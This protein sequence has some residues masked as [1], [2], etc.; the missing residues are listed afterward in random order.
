MAPDARCVIPLAA[1][2]C[3]WRTDSGELVQ[4]FPTKF[5]SFEPWPVQWTNEEDFA[6]RLTAEGA[7]IVLPGDLSTVIPSSRLAKDSA[8][9]F[10]VGPTGLPHGVCTF[11][12]R[13][14]S[15]PGS[16]CVWAFPRV[17]EP[18][19]AKAMEADDARCE[20]SSDGQRVLFELRTDT[21]ATSY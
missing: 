20:F 19:A 7:V 4:A 3:I 18:A 10:W 9:K 17:S 14:K 13:T 6:F 1:N 8:M 5:I 15:K 21:S 16:M 11:V 2:M 12:P